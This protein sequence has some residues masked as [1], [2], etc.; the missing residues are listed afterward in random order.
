MTPADIFK[1]EGYVIIRKFL[2]DE[3][4]ANINVF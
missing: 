1:K 2:S 4:K 3:I